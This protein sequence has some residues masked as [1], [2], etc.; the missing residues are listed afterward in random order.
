MC[1]I[2]AFY[3]FSSVDNST[4]S[5]LHKCNQ[6]M[7][8]RGPDDSGLWHDERVAIAHVRLSIIGVENGHQPLFNEDKSL[9][10]TCNGE[11]YNYLELKEDLI[12]KGHCFSTESDCEVI[13]HLYEEYGTNFISK[14]DGMFAFCLYDQKKAEI[15]V[16]RDHAGKKPL[17]YAVLPKGVI[18]SSELKAIK[19]HFLVNPDTNYEVI[20]QVQKYT[21]SISRNETYIKQ[22]EKIPDGCYATLNL[23]EGL[24]INRYFRRTITPS[25]SG[26]Y[27][28]AKS[29]TKDLIYSAVEKRLQSE[30]P[31]AILLSAGVDSSTIACVA[32]ELREEVHV[33]TAGYKG[34][35]DVDERAEAQ[36]LAKEKDLIWHDVELDSRD[37]AD[38]FDE[39]LSYLDE[40]N[41]DPAMFAQWHIYRKAKE[42]GFTV[43]LGGNGADELFYGYKKHNEYAQSLQWYDSYRKKILNTSRISFLKNSLKLF[44]KDDHVTYKN[45]ITGFSERKADNEVESKALLQSLPLSFESWISNLPWT[46]TDRLYY[47]LHYAWL[48]N[49]CY[50]LSDKLAMAHSIEVRSPFADQELIKFI[51]SLPLEY[52]F[53]NQ[54]PKQLL[55]EAVKG[56]VPDNVL[57]RTKTGFTPPND[58]M[59]Y[60]LKEQKTTFSHYLSKRFIRK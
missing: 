3:A 12:K 1:G 15:I 53:P 23:N 43:L 28:D 55:K 16:G 5:N 2:T 56:L 36:K 51:D 33:I 8:Y 26:S 13:I 48:T 20:R 31:V 42:L 50:F 19:N 21:Y 59:R 6:E 30:V 11:I 29:R 34:S 32:R 47:Y 44:K 49:N 25:F 4:L 27:E 24:R 54:A 22:I 38:S 37:F 52:K 7:S 60:L 40:P 46:Y 10:L 18:L 58:H 14:L 39:I 41:A 45:Y 17:Y 9:I 35:H 57:N